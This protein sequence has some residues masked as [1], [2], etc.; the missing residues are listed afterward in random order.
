[1]TSNVQHA[2]N[3]IGIPNI[4]KPTL[5]LLVRANDKDGYGASVGY[6][7]ADPALVKL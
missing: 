6:L 2:D 1:M 5:E 7:T 3:W 4:V